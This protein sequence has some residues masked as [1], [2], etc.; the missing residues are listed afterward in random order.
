[1]RLDSFPLF[2]S[3][4]LPLTS[5]V[6]YSPS[7]LAPSLLSSLPFPALSF[8]PSHREMEC[9][10]SALCSPDA[11]DPLEV[12]A[13]IKNVYPL[14][15]ATFAVGSCFFEHVRDWLAC[16]CPHLVFSFTPDSV[17]VCVLPLMFCVRWQAIECLRVFVC[18]WNGVS[19]GSDPALAEP[20]PEDFWREELK[21]ADKA[22]DDDDD[23]G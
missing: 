7:S 4:P 15:K 6:V 21:W 8:H 2:G 5:S 23:E 11:T 19:I 20:S 17:C 14:K 12:L 18:A 16:K 1:M 3:T 9:L 22:L 10:L 13:C